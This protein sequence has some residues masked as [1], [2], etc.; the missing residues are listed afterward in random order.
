[1]RKRALFVG[2]TLFWV[3]AAGA[4][5][6]PVAAPGAATRA[7]AFQGAL[8]NG[9][10]AFRGIPYAEAPVGSRRWQPPQPVTQHSGIRGATGFGPVCPQAGSGEPMEED[11][12]TLN[13][14]TPGLDNGARPVMVW[15]HGGGFRAG[16]GNVP[17]QSFAAQGVAFVSINYRLG[18]L[19]FFAH[20]ALGG[21]A[22]NFGLMD[23]VLALEW[24]RDN[25]AAF[26]GDPG[27]VTIFGLSAGGMAVSLLLAS[28]AA[29]GL[30]HG[31]IA[32]SGYG[33][34]ALPR[35]VNAPS[36]APL[37][38]D[39][40]GADSAES[41]AQE[42]IARV[43]RNARTAD[44][45]RAL[46]AMALMQAVQGFHLPVVDGATL[47]EEPGILFLAGKHHDVPVVTGGTSFDGSVMPHSGI[48]KEAY[49]RTWGEDY[50]AAQALYR[51]DFD[52]APERGIARLFGDSRYLLAARTLAQGMVR[53]RSP[54]WLYY[55]DVP[56][57]E[58]LSDSPGTPHDYDG[59][60][61]FA[62]GIL[63]DAEQQALAERL[64]GYWLDFA[65]SGNPNDGSRLR[66]PEY[67]TE[68]D[69]WLVFGRK[70]QVRRGV[71]R[72]R[73]DFIAVRYQQRIERVVH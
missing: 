42:L 24:V 6:D 56:V 37:G 60:L 73:L 49:E 48:S 13:V 9:V 54:A 66:W 50:P 67:R 14:W 10:Y 25:I 59:Q 65:R 8:E 51:E 40:Q 70:D 33:T 38:M 45:L 27:K 18:P 46:D 47:P 34:W 41:M 44:E 19:G 5:S 35:T 1:M 43:S 69:G 29:E 28:D 61:L 72:E 17:G 4:R 22:A 31:A 58:P 36:P 64:T 63:R 12:L 23:M 55:L 30:F 68:E 53:K 39:L 3:C 57:A 11:C 15:I 32:Q 62:G 2:L 52:S 16:S 21:K 20:P 71:V 26:G 7:G